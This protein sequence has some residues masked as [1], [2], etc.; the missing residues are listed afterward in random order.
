MEREAHDE[1]CA[2]AEFGFKFD[3]AA[4]LLHDHHVGDG[5]PLAGAFAYRFGGKKGSKIRPRTASGMPVPVS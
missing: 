3:G 1:G 4:M 5:Q 2:L